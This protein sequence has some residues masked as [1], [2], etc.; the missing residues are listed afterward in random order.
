MNETSTTICS[1]ASYL[2]N[3]VEWQPENRLF[4]NPLNFTEIASFFLL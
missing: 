3:T 2:V 4:S 1:I